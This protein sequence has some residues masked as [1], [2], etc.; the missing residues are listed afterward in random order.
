MYDPQLGRWHAVDPLADQMRRHSPYNYAF[1]NPLRF[2]DPDGMKPT[3]D[4]YSMDGKFLHRD[5]KKTN[6]IMIVSR[7]GEALASLT[8]VNGKGHGSVYEKLLQS[9]ST[10][11]GK[12][13][14]IDKPGEKV[15]EKLSSKAASAIFTHILSQTEG[16][17]MS[18]LHNGKVS[19]Q[20]DGTKNDFN[21]PAIPH[22]VANTTYRKGVSPYADGGGYT[23][24]GTGDYKVTV[25]Y[26]QEGRAL[27]SELETVSGV[28][29]MLGAHEAIGHGQ[30]G[31]RD[32]KGTHYKAYEYQMNQHP[33]WKRTNEE[34]RKG[35]KDRYN[36]HINPKR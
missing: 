26:G 29:N 21:D 12:V 35:I 30:E 19:I 15:T 5:N 25:M 2:I 17:D 24:P 7:A 27:A 33:S 3:D 16:V 13:N 18:R 9:N 4:Y 22:G 36:G 31:Y 32:S 6:N 10:S 11:I 23:E 20:G 28:Q 8:G 34:Y 14:V 1:N